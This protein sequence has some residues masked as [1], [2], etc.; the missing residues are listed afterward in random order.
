MKPTIAIIIL[1][2]AFTT[3]PAQS[4]SPIQPA[5]APHPTTYDR[6]FWLTTFGY[7]ASVTADIYSSRGRY[8]MNP[9]LRGHDGHISV[10]KAVA[11]SAIPYTLS[12][13]LQR[14]HPKPATFVRLFGA[15]VHDAA[16]LSNLT[17]TWR[18]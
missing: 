2:L 6:T 4:P 16:A 11:F 10:P 5:P 18:Q 14:R 3:I 13:V 15:G 8:E 7:T 1:L 12:V 9:L 17:G